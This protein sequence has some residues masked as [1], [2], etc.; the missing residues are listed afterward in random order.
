[1]LH[2]HIATPPWT[3]RATTIEIRKR[4]FK[5]RLVIMGDLFLLVT[6]PTLWSPLLVDHEILSNSGHFGPLLKSVLTSQ[7]VLRNQATFHF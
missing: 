1:M 5:I 7:T 6:M 2:V 3:K 4:E